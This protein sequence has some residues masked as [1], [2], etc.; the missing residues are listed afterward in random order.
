[1]KLCIKC[2]NE[3]S[4][5]SYSKDKTRKDGLS[6]RCKACDHLKAVLKD[7]NPDKYRLQRIR[8]CERQLVYWQNELFKLQ[9]HS[10][11]NMEG[12]K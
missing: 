6:A 11:L 9:M 10:V 5:D 2:R 7:R 3:F 1:M 12:I 8:K 4:L